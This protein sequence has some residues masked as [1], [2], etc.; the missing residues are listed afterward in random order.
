MAMDFYMRDMYG[1]MGLLDTRTQV[2]PE[3][4]DK[5]ALEED[6]SARE[7]VQAETRT[8]VSAKKIYMGI[9]VLVLLAVG[10]GLLHD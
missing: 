1:N 2:Q 10:L 4:T 8:N 9:G 5:E 3:A 7:K 6:A